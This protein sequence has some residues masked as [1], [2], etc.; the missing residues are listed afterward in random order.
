MTA[1]AA[2]A[3]TTLNF[4]LSSIPLDDFV[5]CFFRFMPALRAY[6]SAGEP[7]VATIVLVSPSS[8]PKAFLPNSL[9]LDGTVISCAEV[10]ANAL[11]VIP[12][13]GIPSISEGIL[14]FLLEPL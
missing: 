8:S 14:T 4:V 12:T 2:Q 1:N 3:A 10:L 13:T 9:T 7:L 6:A 5:L 11:S